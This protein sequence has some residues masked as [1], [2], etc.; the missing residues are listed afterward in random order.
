MTVPATVNPIVSL[1]TYQR[2]AVEKKDP[3]CWWCWSRQVGKSHALSLRRLI[4]GLKRKRRQIFMSAGERQSAELMDKIRM[5]LSALKIASS[6]TSVFSEAK[7]KILQVDIPGYMKIIAIPSNPETAR[8][9]TGDVF[10]DEF[11]MHEKDVDVWGSIMPSIM[12]DQGELDVASTPKG[13]QNMFAKFRENAR[14]SKSTITIHDAHRQGLNVDVEALR[15]LCGDEMLWR[16]EFLCEFIDGASV[17]LLYSEIQSCQDD[18]ATMIQSPQQIAKIKYPLYAGLDIGRRNDNTVFWA[19]SD[20]DGLF[21]TELVLVMKN[22]MFSEQRNTVAEYLNAA[23]ITLTVDASPI[24]MQLTEELAELFGA[25]RIIGQS[26]TMAYKNRIA[27]R[28]KV[29]IQSQ[30]LLIPE[31]EAILND[32]HSIQKS[33]TPSGNVVLDSPRTKESHGDRF[34][35]AA[36]ALDSAGNSLAGPIPMS[37]SRKGVW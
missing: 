19:V 25:H 31:D 3:W 9:Y 12:R 17:H 13:V 18:S 22:T 6:P 11:A 20:R 2:S 14:M 30:T 29:A 27:G 1:P 35:A 36:M 7:V 15:E 10:L 28:M 21:V 24:G 32:F 37:F 23:P 34:W 8:G 5:H 4:R 33:V 26:F 16:Q